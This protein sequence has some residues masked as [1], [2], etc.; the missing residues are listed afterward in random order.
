MTNPI[1][2]T[3]PA[4]SG[5]SMTA[6]IFYYSGAWGG[7][8]TGPT[9]YNKKGQFENSAIRNS[10]KKLLSDMGLDPLCQNPLPSDLD[11]DLISVKYLWWRS[12]VNKIIVS[13][14]Y[15]D[16][17]PWFYKGA[18]MVLMWR[19]WADAF[20]NAK[21]IYVNRDIDGIIN[22]C[23][24]TGFMRAYN[25]REGWKKWVEKHLERKEEMRQVGIKIIDTYSE[26]IIRGDFERIRSIVD[27][28]GLN[29]NEKLINGFIEPR[30]WGG[31]YGQK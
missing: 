13:Q 5:T 25:T 31:V 11:N 24:K 14:G 4:R 6:G 23:L 12:K 8:M 7:D 29:W 22:S 17:S 18:K 19:L 10:V 30:Y 28:F 3:G 26:E 1:L 16:Q 15:N 2:I 27:K 21:W 9:P 20:P